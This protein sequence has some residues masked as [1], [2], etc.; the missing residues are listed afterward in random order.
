MEG[1]RIASTSMIT[2]DNTSGHPGSKSNINFPER[3]EGEEC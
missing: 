1:T 2:T 3:D